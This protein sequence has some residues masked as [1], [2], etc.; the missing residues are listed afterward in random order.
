MNSFIIELWR[1][2][3]SH[4]NTAICKFN[5]D[6]SVPFDCV[7]PLHSDHWHGTKQG[8][9][10]HTPPTGV[11]LPLTLFSSET[12]CSCKPRKLSKRGSF[13]LVCLCKKK[14]KKKKLAAVFTGF[15]FYSRRSPP[16]GRHSLNSYNICLCQDNRVHSANQQHDNGHISLRH[17][18]ISTM[19]YTVKAFKAFFTFWMN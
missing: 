9:T 7:V 13:S 12:F 6:G 3:E 11:T 2:Y 1:T 8:Q 15:W 5:T 18:I 16:Y 14:N 17:K 10:S 19:K 4:Q